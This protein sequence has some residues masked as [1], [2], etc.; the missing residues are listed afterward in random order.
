MRVAGSIA[1]SLLAC[2]CGAPES[3]AQ[4]G[5][6]AKPSSEQADL[7]IAKPVQNEAKADQP[8]RQPQEKN[9]CRTQ[10]GE[11][12]KHAVKA[13]GTEPFWAAEVD[14]RC[15]SYK[16][17]ANQQGTRVW[18]KVKGTPAQFEWNGALHGKQFQLTIR[19]MAD[20]SDGMSDRIYPLEA[21]LLVDGERRKGC[22]ERL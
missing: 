4:N 10:E 1:C 19:P 6:A 16:T 9:A 12:L 11:S 2:A 3:Q 13:V 20:C 7:T 22:A 14:G 5:A 21:V 8:T 18:T 15:V 17:P